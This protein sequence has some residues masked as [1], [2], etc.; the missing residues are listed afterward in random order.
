MQIHAFFRRSSIIVRDKIERYDSFD[1]PKNS[2]RV[3][4]SSLSREI[5]FEANRID[6]TELDARVLE[7][8]RLAGNRFDERLHAMCADQKA[9]VIW[10]EH[11]REKKG[12]IIC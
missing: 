2:H 3:S 7:L 11:E 4:Q 5:N 1:R 8:S 9:T 6:W 12:L 10:C